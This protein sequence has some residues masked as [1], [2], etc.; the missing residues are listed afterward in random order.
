MSI[1]SGSPFL[2]EKLSAVVFDW[3]GVT[4]D[5]GSRAPVLAMQAAFE[6][7]G[8]RVT[9]LEVRTHMGKA[10]REHLA[11]ILAEQRIQDAW[12]DT[13]GSK[14]QEADLDNIYREFLSFQQECI[15]GN[16]AVIAGCVEAVRF[17]RELGM[18]IGSSTGYTRELLAPAAARAREE[19][20]EPDSIVCAGD[21]S[22]GRPA[23]WLLLENAK[24]LD[25]YPMAGVLKVDDTPAGIAAGLNAGAWAV[26]VVVSG[27]E[28]GLSLE[29]WEA[30]PAERQQSLRESAAKRLTDAGAHSL[31]DTIADLPA[32]IDQINQRLL[33]RESPYAG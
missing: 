9:E 11:A 33:N 22:P 15:A 27:N 3:A 4:V 24:R 14:P 21:V 20:Y 29:E 5:F 31:I 17:C 7:A 30:L 16:S 28:T 18:K 1:Q 32:A 10:K 25:V 19:G 2:P 6:Q 26:G 13:H 23:P 8:V 12:Q